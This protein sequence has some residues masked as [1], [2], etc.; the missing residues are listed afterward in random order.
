M[1]NNILT[2]ID[3]IQERV[4][5]LAG[6]RDLKVI[7]FLDGHARHWL[8]FATFAFLAFDQE[9]ELKLTV[10][11]GTSGFIDTTDD[12]TL[13]IPISHV[14]APSPAVPGTPFGSLILVPG[15][16]ETLRI[17]GR[18]SALQ[19]DTILVTVH[20]CYLHCA[21]ALMRSAFWDANEHVDG[22]ESVDAF[23]QI[24][25]F[26]A[27]ATVNAEGHVDVSPKGD[28][29][30]SLLHYSGGD[31]LWYSDRP[32][33]RRI[34]SFRN[35]MER[36]SVSLLALIPGCD[37]MLSVR[38]SCEIRVDE[39]K[40]ASFEVQG[41]RPKLVTRVS[42]E[43]S[44][45]VTSKALSASSMWPVQSIP[46]INAAEIFKSHFKQSKERGLGVSMTRVVASLPGVIER[47]LATDYKNNLY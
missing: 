12:H 39:D 37:H 33:N 34:D 16:R 15:M 44:Q 13:R 46:E 8:S 3:D 26:M 47:G 27:L 18:V 31:E 25:P 6:A 35:I 41:K 36:A 7:D 40:L 11:G 1:T 14:D 9:H 42:I 38:G 17:N 45:I 10:A 28:P 21:K 4:G 19:D 22:P 20:E 30:G 43:E 32:G 29:A 2:S 5:P 23:V 24:S